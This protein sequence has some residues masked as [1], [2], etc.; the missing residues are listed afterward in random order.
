MEPGFR[1]ATPDELERD[2]REFTGGSPVIG[3]LRDYYPADVEGLVWEDSDGDRRAVVSWRIDG[4]RA[5]IVSLHA[6]PTGAGVG[7][8]IMNAAEDELRRRGVSKIVL[9]TTNDNVGALT[10]YQKLGYRLVR[11]HLDE[12]ENVRDAKP[13]VPEIG[14]NGIPLRD[15]WELEKHLS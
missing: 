7:T 15:M 3:L 14:Q 12:M 13:G 5:E 6:Q 10:F 9:A 11:L 1:T 8:R 2:W 4:D